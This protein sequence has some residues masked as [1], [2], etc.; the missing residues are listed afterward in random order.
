MEPAQ[1]ILVPVSPLWLVAGGVLFAYA[2]LAGMYLRPRWVVDH[3]W[4]VLALLVAVSLA[5]A[6]ALV[7]VRAWDVRVRLDASEEPLMLRGDPA[8]AEYAQAVRTFGNDDTFVI[9]MLTDGDVFAHDDLAALR[10]ISDGVVRLPGVRRVESLVDAL[11]YR[12]SPERDRV[13][14]EKFIR[15]VPSDSAEL[16][17]LRRRALADPIYPKLIVSRDGGAAALNVSFHPIS[18]REFVDDGLDARIREIAERESRPGRVFRFA[19]RPHVKSQTTEIMSRDLL[20]LIPLAVVV[21]A[22]VVFLT[23]GSARGVML[24]LL[25]CLT[26]VLWTFGLLAATGTS[27]NLLTIVLAPI[28]ISLGGLYGVHI[29]A[30]WELEREHAS[31]SRA[32][33][34]ATLEDVFTPELLSGITTSVGFAALIPGGIP[35]IEQLGTFAFFGT[36]ML[37]V[38]SLAGIPAALAV[39]PHKTGERAATRFGVAIGRWLDDALVWLAD[40]CCRHAS[41]MLVSWAAVSAVAVAA[42]FHIVIDTDY[43]TFFD[44]DSEVRRDFAEV[45]ERLGGPVPLYVELLGREEGEFREPENLRFVERLSREL[46]SLPGVSAAVSMADPLRLL[47]RAMEH[48]DPAEE[49]IP[50]SREAVSD[51]VFLVPKHEMR[52]FA[53]SNHSEANVLVRTGE[54]GSRAIRTLVARIRETAERIG[55]PPGIELVVTGN[56]VALNRSADALAGN[57]LSGILTA[58]ATIFAL[59]WWVFRSARVSALVMIPNVTPVLLFFGL[60]GIGLAPLSLPTSMIG[61]VALGVAVDDTVHLLVTYRRLRETGVESLDAVRRT[62]R[63]VGRPMVISALM[64][65]AGFLTITV[66]GFATIREF[67]WLSALTM[68]VCLA[69]DLLMLPALLARARV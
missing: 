40:R 23:T 33:A 21:A 62:V 57:Q 67:G 61:C 8:L 20:R 44:R 15:D 11:S 64:L 38:I 4:L 6:V 30:R 45:T 59:V 39:L 58:T 42:V 18:D 43:L 25:T 32:A 56:A 29:V 41:G 35:G 14:V 50:D 26:S 22:L 46:E 10:R 60:L 51:L 19:G 66:S 24:P 28:L 49:R 9:A 48:G 16:A 53:S 3:A 47:N 68:A 1:T 37:T 69:A 7:D 55:L 36:S 27:I 63:Q 13:E 65:M 5:A 34:Q 54:L 2:C 12:F 52:R 31:D 17:D